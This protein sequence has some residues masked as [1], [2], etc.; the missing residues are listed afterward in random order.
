[1]GDLGHYRLTARP[2][3]C[4]HTQTRTAPSL[5]PRPS[6]SP[7]V[8]LD[9]PGYKADIVTRPSFYCHVYQTESL[10]MRQRVWEWDRGSGNETGGLGMRQR[11]WE[12][13]YP[14]TTKRGRSQHCSG[15]LL[16]LLL[17][18]W[19]TKVHSKKVHSKVGF[20]KSSGISSKTDVSSQWEHCTSRTCI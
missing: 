19:T 5:V 4:T 17:F 9:L 11:V 2:T 1:M 8:E 20:K 10:R 13:D 7:V 16:L 18:E 12:R 6:L 15:I 14:S 3:L